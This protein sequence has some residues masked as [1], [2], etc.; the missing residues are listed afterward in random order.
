M[1]GDELWSAFL[2]A[3]CPD[4]DL[5]ALGNDIG[6]KNDKP[7]LGA[8]RALLGIADKAGTSATMLF[9]SLKDAMPGLFARRTLLENLA[10]AYAAK[11]PWALIDDGVMAYLIKVAAKLPRKAPAAPPTP[12]APDVPAAGAGGVLLTAVLGVGVAFAAIAVTTAAKIAR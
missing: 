5:E 3:G 4:A 2:S 9:E 7:S 11:T 8:A 6:F 12:K 10:E 1:Q